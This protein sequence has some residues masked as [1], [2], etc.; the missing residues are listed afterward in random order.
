MWLNPHGDARPSCCADPECTD[1]PDQQTRADEPS[2]QVADPAA[3]GD[4]KDAE[5]G[6]GNRRSNNAEH[7][8][9]HQSHITLHELL[10]KPACNPAD[11]N[12]RDP[13]NC[14]VFHGSSPSKGYSPAPLSKFSDASV[15]TVVCSPTTNV[16]QRKAKAVLCLSTVSFSLGAASLH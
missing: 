8:V 12:G 4:S 9:H 10:S 3:Q 7:D 14:W 6:A 11:Y 2:N 15:Q 5:N 16:S 13:T 1:D